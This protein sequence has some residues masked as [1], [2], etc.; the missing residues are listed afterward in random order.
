MTSINKIKFK[1]KNVSVFI[2]HKKT[3]SLTKAIKQAIIYIYTLYK[4]FF[5][6]MSNDIGGLSFSK[7]YPKVNPCF[8]MLKSSD[9]TCNL[10]ISEL[11]ACYAHMMHPWDDTLNNHLIKPFILDLCTLISLHILF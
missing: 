1:T 10:F 8:V 2:L 3:D 6:S 5:K 7:N 11:H 4:I 9:I